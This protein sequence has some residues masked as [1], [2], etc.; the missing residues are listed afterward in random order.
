MTD[1]SIGRFSYINSGEVHGCDIGNFCS[2]GQGV[3]IG[4]FGD[5][6]RNIS[7][8]PAFY[9]EFPPSA[10][11]FHKVPEHRD[12]QRVL[13]GHDVWIGDRA[14]ILDGVNVGTGSIIGAGAVVTRDVNPFEI[15]AGVPARRIKSRVPECYVESLVKSQWW[16]LDI[17]S[18]RAIAPLIASNDY[19]EF[20]KQV[21]LLIGA[22]K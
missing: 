3:K 12:F 6:P 8:H 9:S 21:K 7:T 22:P 20:L 10:L 13:I 4:G 18:I 14:L 15:V 5:H 16:S 2:I 19:P 17:N 11:S 1:A